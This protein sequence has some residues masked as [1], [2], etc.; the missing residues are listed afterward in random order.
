MSKSRRPSRSVGSRRDVRI[1]YQLSS[2][3]HRPNDLVKYAQLAEEHGF[4]FANISD[5]FHPWTDTQ[6][7]SP[8]VWTV[9]GGIAHATER[10]KLGTWVT[11]PTMRMHPAIVAHAAATAAAMME[12]RF[13]LG[14]GTGENL[15]EHIVGAGWPETEVRQERLEE[16][17]GII[18]LLWEG[19]NKSHHGRYYTVEN[20][21]LYTLPKEPPPLL[22][23]VGGASSAE[24]AGRAGDG[25]IATSPER[26]LIEIF[27]KAGGKGKPRYGS[28]TVCWAK[29]EK[30]ARRTAHRIWPTVAME[31]SLSW[32]LPLPKHFEDV[33]KLVTEDAVA[34]EIVCG[35]DPERHIKAIMKY[36][37]AGFD[38]VGIHQV[39][40]D[41]AGFFRFYATEVLPR[42]TAVNARNAHC[43]AQARP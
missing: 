39:G 23:A 26:D 4:S 41:Q 34:E 11:C 20:A 8:F 30:A 33:A 21:R 13:F 32:E 16:A 28:L 17:I 14:V 43:E 42:L 22:V 40:P 12:G 24:M 19:G 27:D 35:P 31:S 38:H 36:V 2:E 29:D 9:I 10:L 3:E 7:Q 18:R 37:E 5:H 1:G 15:N 25:F 6:G